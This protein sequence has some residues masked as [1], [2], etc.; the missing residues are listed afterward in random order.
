MLLFVYYNP[1]M[2]WTL[3]IIKM[4]ETYFARSSGKIIHVYISIIGQLSLTC[5]NMYPLLHY[6]LSIRECW[7]HQSP[8][9]RRHDNC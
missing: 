1:M 4:A 2:N 6:K 7:E 3:I 8:R 5:T 9:T